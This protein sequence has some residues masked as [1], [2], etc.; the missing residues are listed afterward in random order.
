MIFGAKP[1]SAWKKCGE[2]K[3]TGQKLL[4]AT[5]R[6][7]GFATWKTERTVHFRRNTIRSIGWMDKED[8]RMKIYKEVDAISFEFWSGA[9]DTVKYLTYDEIEEVFSM[10]EDSE[11]DGMDEA[12]VNDFFWFEDDTIADWLGWP[13][14]E[15]LM[16]A[17]SGE[18]WYDT[19]DEYEEYLEEME[20]EE[21]DEEAE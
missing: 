20:D 7:F 18:N 21:E 3:N 1:M 15:T 11:P 10:L 9:K 13:D 16:D 12:A 6:G 19:Y 5:C 4:P 14:F 2:W 17:R 8:L